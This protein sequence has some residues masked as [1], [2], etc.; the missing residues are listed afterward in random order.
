[1]DFVYC[2]NPNEEEPIMLIDKH[3]GYDSVD[4][5]GIMGD[6]FQKELLFL[7]SLGK[8]RVKIYINSIGGSVVDGMSI[9]N[10]ILKSN[11]KVDTYCTGIAAS[12]AAVIHQA[13][14]T[15]YMADY[16]ILMFHNPSGT[17][18]KETYDKIKNSIATMIS[19][20]CGKT[21]DDVCKMMDE[22]SWI[23]ANEALTGGFCDEVENS[24]ES[25]KKRLKVTQD[26][27]MAWK[28][29]SLLM[30]KLIN[31]NTN[32]KK[33]TNKLNLQVEA[34]EDAIVLAIEEIQN[35]A[36]INSARVKELETEKEAIASD[37]LKA[38]NKVSELEGKIT[39]VEDAEKA[40]KLTVVKNNAEIFIKEAAKV[41]KIKNDATVIKS[42][43]DKVNSEEEFESVKSLVESIQI[44]KSAKNIADEVKDSDTTI[45][46]VIAQSMVDLRNKSNV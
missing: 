7:D 41:G 36:N 37:L 19:S 38:K 5:I 4:G 39:S 40:A 30:N 20:R 42:W 16:G 33:V 27:T 8:K 13:G 12:I 15:R 22:V 6:Q 9:Y 28:E 31:T 44:S 35:K 26:V 25:N 21:F 2:V 23:D 11:C 14:R 3:I 29:A 45:G 43:V 18:D 17:D 46:S 24:N 1:M 10:A 32:M 34:S